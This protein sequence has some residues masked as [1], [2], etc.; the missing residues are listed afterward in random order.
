MR[1]SL[2]RLCTVAVLALAFIFAG[3]TKK[4]EAKTYSF[5]AKELSA[6][7][8]GGLKFEDVLGEVDESIL[9]A[10]YEI[11]GTGI[12][13]MSAY[14]S[15]TATTE[16]I[17]VFVCKDVETAKSIKEKCS[18]RIDRQISVYESYAPNEVERLK[19]AYSEI[20]GNVV[21]LCVSADKEAAASVTDKFFEGLK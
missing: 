4:E 3:C 9:T 18:Q 17:A 16:E 14:M 10:Q 21:I 5:E 11:D 13:S 19:G 20:K 8:F 6:A 2:I 12:S 7:L 1:A 15:T